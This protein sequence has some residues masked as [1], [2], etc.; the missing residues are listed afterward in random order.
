[1]STKTTFKRVALVAVAALGLGVMSVVPSN[2]AAQLDSISVSAASTT[3]NTT[4][5]LT[6]TAVTVTGTL[7]AV[8]GVD[9][10][11]VTAT[12]QSGPAYVAPVLAL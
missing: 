3:Q 9:T 1:M 7:A 12:I 11:T 4:E 10:L 8:K 6:A 5:T 2:A